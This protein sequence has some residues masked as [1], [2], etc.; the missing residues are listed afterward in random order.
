MAM[1][2]SG[3]RLSI[4]TRDAIWM[5]VHASEFVVFGYN[6]V[7]QA[8]KMLNLQNIKCKMA[9]VVMT[10]IKRQCKNDGNREEIKHHLT[11]SRPLKSLAF[12][13]MV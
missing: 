3:M 4:D 10:T 5:R 12:C 2:G 8:T 13:V 6:S 1:L 7:H 11:I 9:F